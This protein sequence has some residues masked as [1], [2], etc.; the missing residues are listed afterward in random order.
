MG[1]IDPEDLDCV[2]ARPVKTPGVQLR[3]G[4]GGGAKNQPVGVFEVDR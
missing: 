1:V 2:Y 3:E 4:V